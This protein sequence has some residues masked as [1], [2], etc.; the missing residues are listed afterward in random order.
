MDFVTRTLR[1]RSRSAGQA[2]PLGGT[3]AV[4]RTLD[5]VR[6]RIG[7]RFPDEFLDEF[8]GE[9]PGE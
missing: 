3:L 6:D 9:F 7:V 2:V 8:P 4:M 5:A 1:C